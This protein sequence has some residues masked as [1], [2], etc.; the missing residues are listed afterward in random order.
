MNPFKILNIDRN[1]SKKEIIHA[2]ALA[3]REKQYSGIELAKAQKML[4]D[5]VSRTCQEF[6]HFPDIVNPIK[7]PAA[8]QFQELCP[9]EPPELN[10]LNIFR[11]KNE[12]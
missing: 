9:A 3:M 6:L 11:Q 1:S 12:T 2:V 7:Q 5:P 10:Y 8:K 4:L